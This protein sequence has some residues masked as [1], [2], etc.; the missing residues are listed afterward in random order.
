MFSQ[1]RQQ[2]VPCACPLLLHSAATHHMYVYAATQHSHQP[3]RA[4]KHL[5]PA[6]LAAIRLTMPLE[7]IGLKQRPQVTVSCLCAPGCLW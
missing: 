4:C 3:Y 2:A 6:Y 1:R 7:C 5:R